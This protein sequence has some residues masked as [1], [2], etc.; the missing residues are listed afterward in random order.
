MLNGGRRSKVEQHR[1]TLY[2]HVSYCNNE[3]FIKGLVSAFPGDT[4]NLKEG[5]GFLTVLEQI[6]G[7]HTRG[8]MTHSAS[9]LFCDDCE[10]D[11]TFSICWKRYASKCD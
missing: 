11:S 6:N 10:H 3:D 4:V 8:T 9:F 2:G 1:L 5:N 7:L